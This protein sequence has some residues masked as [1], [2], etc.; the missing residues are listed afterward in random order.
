MDS[1]PLG[2]YLNGFHGNDEISLSLIR[3]FWDSPT[4][5]D[6]DGLSSCADSI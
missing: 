1:R 4:G 3:H 2:P 5:P 6:L